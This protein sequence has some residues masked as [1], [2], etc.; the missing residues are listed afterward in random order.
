MAAGGGEWS[1]RT[2]GVVALATTPHSRFRPRLARAARAK[3]RAGNARANRLGLQRVSSTTPHRRPCVGVVAAVSGNLRRTKTGGPRAFLRSRSWSSLFNGWV[4]G[5]SGDG[6]TSLFA[7]AGG[8]EWS[9]AALWR[10]SRFERAL[11]ARAFARAASEG[12]AGSGSSR[13]GQRHDANVPGDHSPPPA[14]PSRRRTFPE[15]TPRRAAPVKATGV[16]SQLPTG[17]R[18]HGRARLGES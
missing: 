15:T 14:R 6:A 16:G 10:P 11:P 3:A 8:G 1:P 17:G 2:F 4:G 18:L 7:S 9:P 13:R 5:G 12:E